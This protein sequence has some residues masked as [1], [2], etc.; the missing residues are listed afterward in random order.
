MAVVAWDTFG[1]PTV[2]N[3]AGSSS[4]TSRHRIHWFSHSRS[5]SA[6]RDAN[7]GGLDYSEHCFQVNGNAKTHYP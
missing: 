6:H 7:H 1:A 4:K 5:G 3:F 2:V